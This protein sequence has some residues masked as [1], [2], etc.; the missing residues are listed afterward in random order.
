MQ[1]K[2]YVASSIELNKNNGA[3]WCVGNYF[4]L[5]DCNAWD[6]VMGRY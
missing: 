4:H 3:V 5:L 1:L 6:P 2:E